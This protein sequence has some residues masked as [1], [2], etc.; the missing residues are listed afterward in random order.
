MKKIIASL[1]AVTSLT[2]LA[3]CTQ[4]ERASYNASREADNFNV[5]RRLVVVNTVTDTVLLEMVG[6]ISV[7]EDRS[8]GQ[9]QLEVTALQPDNTVRKHLVG[10]PPT[11]VYTVEDVDGSSVS[12]SRYQISYMPE[13]VIPV[14]FKNAND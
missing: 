6:K 14:E 11:V 1:L 5:E 8:E 4:A 12:L 10:L 2:V 3:A 13:A 9:N 7:R